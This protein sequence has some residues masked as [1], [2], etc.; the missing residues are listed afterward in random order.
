M[1]LNFTNLYLLDQIS[2]SNHFGWEDH[3]VKAACLCIIVV[4]L[5]LH[6]PTDV[7]DN[8][9]KTAD[10]SDRDRLLW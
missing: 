1:L 8:N 5:Q 4:K 6:N 7:R 10:L 2:A 9:N 3:I